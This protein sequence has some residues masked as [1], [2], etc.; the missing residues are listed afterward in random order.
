MPEL[1]DD[2]LNT[3]P[4]EEEEQEFARNENMLRRVINN[5][6]NLYTN[7]NGILSKKFYDNVHID[8]TIVSKR[9]NNK[10][11]ITMNWTNKESELAYAMLLT[12]DTRIKLNKD[13]IFHKIIDNI[14]VPAV[15]RAR[16]EF[17]EELKYLSATKKIEKKEI[18]KQKMKTIREKQK[19]KK[20]ISVKKA[21][22]NYYHATQIPEEA[23]YRS[24][25]QNLYSVIPL[26]NIEFEELSGY[27]TYKIKIEI[28][29]FLSFLEWLVKDVVTNK[30][31]EVILKHEFDITKGIYYPQIFKIL[32]YYGFD[33]RARDRFNNIIDQTNSGFPKMIDFIITAGHFEALKQKMYMIKVNENYIITKIDEAEEY[34][35]ARLFIED[36][37]TFNKIKEEMKK[38]YKLDKYDKNSFYYKSNL[39]LYNPGQYD[40]HILK[41]N[42]GFDRMKTLYNA[43]NSICKL[44]GFLNKESE[45]YFFN[46]N[47]T[48]TIFNK[49]KKSNLGIDENKA[50][51]SQLLKPNILFPISSICDYWQDYDNSEIILYG[52]YYCI[53]NKFEKDEFIIKYDGVYSGYK[54][55]LIIN[56]MKI[57][58]R[59]IRMF[60]PSYYISSSKFCDD[61][62]IFEGNYECINQYIGWLQRRIDIN[63]Y[64]YDEVDSKEFQ[65]MREFYGNQLKF[66]NRNVRFTNKNII[67]STGKLANML[68]KDLTDIDVYHANKTMMQLNPF[69]KLNACVTDAVYWINEENK[70]INFGNLLGIKPGQFKIIEQSE[71]IS[72]EKNKINRFQN[73]KMKIP[74]AFISRVPICH[75]VKNITQLIDMYKNIILVGMPGT[76]KSWTLKNII[77]PHLKIANKNYLITATTEEASILINGVTL[78]SKISK[79]YYDMLRIFEKIDYLIID[80]GSQLTEGQCKILEFIQYNTSCRFIIIGDHNQC[81]IGNVNIL[82]SHFLLHLMDYNLIELTPGKHSR[83][84]PKLYEHIKYVLENIEDNKK[85]VEYMYKHFKIINKILKKTRNIALLNNTCDKIN[86]KL[87]IKKNDEDKRKCLTVHKVQG[88]TIDEVFTIYNVKEKVGRFKHLGN[89]FYTAISRAREINQIN[90]YK[91]S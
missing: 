74:N 6:F 91:K 80:E 35:N 88:Q 11:R 41:N 36:R 84:S 18:I 28:N 78:Q 8:F 50:Y 61:L 55:N 60:I 26:F 51:P 43:I 68:I 23:Y 9:K 2:Y 31:L 85:I 5:N 64:W 34:K 82:K 63:T 54:V 10:K 66:R 40:H 45:D 20:I 21:V 65:A 62:K 58:I 27:I 17:I 15:K 16:T 77:I 71:Y 79:N 70:K 90:I 46:I 14:Y 42:L 1:D 56:E 52:F 29:C 67:V 24:R 13:D 69:L 73:L 72:I 30:D 7:R 57:N 19:Q 48:V 76:G 33:A 44:T 49:G 12:D 81:S 39:I 4:T 38:K 3:S 75:E 87:G 37:D 47:D 83:C 22:E 59:V 53:V 86:N 25:Y 32:N 89:L